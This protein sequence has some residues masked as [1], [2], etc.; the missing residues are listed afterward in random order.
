MSLST[1]IVGVDS[2]KYRP[3]TDPDVVFC[4]HISNHNLYSWHCN[5][6]A[7]TDYIELV[8]KS[9]EHGTMKISPTA[10]RLHE[11]IRCKAYHISSEYRRKNWRKKN[12]Y[13]MKYTHL[14][15]KRHEVVKVDELESKIEMLNQ[16][17]EDYRCVYIYCM[18]IIE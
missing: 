5:V 7:A 12:E 13:L 11:R 2:S 6:T 3:N 9:I 1:K 10:V 4:L 16:D 8:N 14:D 17:I 15:I 18:I